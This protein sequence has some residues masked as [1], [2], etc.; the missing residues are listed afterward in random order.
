MIDLVNCVE[1]GGKKDRKIMAHHCVARG[2][3]RN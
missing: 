2:N 1:I 3:D